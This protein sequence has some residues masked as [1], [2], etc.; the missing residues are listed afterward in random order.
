MSLRPNLIVMAHYSPAELSFCGDCLRISN[1][2]S[3]CYGC[4]ATCGLVSVTEMMQRPQTHEETSLSPSPV[5]LNEGN[6][7]APSP[8]K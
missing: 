6:A 7:S 8:M 2:T 1:S 5:P 4:G 3:V